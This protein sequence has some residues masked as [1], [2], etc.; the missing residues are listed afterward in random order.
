MKVN[1][2]LFLKITSGDCPKSEANKLFL[3]LKSYP[4]STSWIPRMPDKQTLNKVIRLVFLLLLILPLD[5]SAQPGL[6]NTIKIR[7]NDPAVTVD[8]D[9]PSAKEGEA[10]TLTLEGVSEGKEA[11]V[12]VGREFGQSDV[13]VSDGSLSGTYIFT[14][15]DY[16][17]YIDVKVE[18]TN[19]DI[20]SYPLTVET[21]GAAAGKVSVTV[22]ADGVTGDASTGYRAEAGQEMTVTLKTPLPTTFTLKKTEAFAPNGSWRW[23]DLSGN[24]TVTSL[25]F[26]M[27]ATAVTV[28]F[29]MEEDTTPDVPDVPDTPDVPEVVYYA[30]TLPRVEGA[31]TDPAAGNHPVESGN[32]FT[33]YV[34][35]DAIYDQ[36]VPVITTSDGQTITP[37]VSDGAYIVE[38]VRDDVEIFIDGIRKNEATTNHTIG[39]PGL[40][41]RAADGT[42][43]I[44]SDCGCEATVYTF[45]GRVVY[46]LHLTGGSEQQFTLPRGAYI[47]C[48]GKHTVKFNL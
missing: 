23:T 34:L 20:L 48:A 41:L 42:V 13:S 25:T 31:A 38:N 28:R 18:A 21:P 14:M 24:Q 19:V 7:V 44:V 17:V 2:L 16:A 43:G 37:R 47:L 30:V 26:T 22:T 27:P 11:T 15:P 9:K 10:V 12:T 1:K 29:T 6:N 3:R 33:F 46:R 45:S 32:S 36:S 35:L 40:R 5:L 8:V 4:C 39:L